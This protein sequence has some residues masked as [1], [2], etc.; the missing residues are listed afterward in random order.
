MAYNGFERYVGL[1]RTPVSYFS[2]LST[3]LTEHIALF[4]RCDEVLT[5]MFLY[6]KIVCEI[7][8]KRMGEL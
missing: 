5:N 6:C 7:T 2:H 3:V 8:D 1:Y 4:H